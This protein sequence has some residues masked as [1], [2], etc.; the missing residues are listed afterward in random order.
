MIR[1]IGLKD[2]PEGLL[3]PDRVLRVLRGNL[4]NGKRPSPPS[5]HQALQQHKGSKRSAQVDISLVPVTSG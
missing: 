4:V 1:V 3:R 5:S 2:R